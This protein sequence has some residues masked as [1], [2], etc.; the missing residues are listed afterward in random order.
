M[1]SNSRY[2]EV[3]SLELTGGNQETY[4]TM[5]PVKK[6]RQFMAAFAGM[7]SVIPTFTKFLNK[8]F[9]FSQLIKFRTRIL[10]RLDFTNHAQIGRR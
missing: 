6:M 9:D 10:P 5:E 1:S 4:R 7:K 8:L 2:T 3:E